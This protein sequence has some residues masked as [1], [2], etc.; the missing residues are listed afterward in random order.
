MTNS[1]SS[2]LA[3]GYA[4]VAHPGPAA[5]CTALTAMA[6][7]S[8]ARQ[9]AGPPVGWRHRLLLATSAMFLAQIST[10][11]LND[12]FDRASDELHQPYKPIPRRDLTAAQALAFSLSTGAGSLLLAARCGRPALKTMAFGLASGWAY[13]AG[14]DRRPESW[15]PFLTG[16]ATVPWL[17]PVAVGVEVPRPWF[18]VA[19]GGALGVGLHLANGGPDIERDRLAGR[20][21]LPVLLG[22]R[23]T[24]LGTHL[25]LTVAAALVV[26]SSPGRGRHLAR[27]GALACLGLLGADRLVAKPGRGPG[28]HPFVLPVLGAGCLAGGWLC[29]AAREGGGPAGALPA[30]T[31]ASGSAP[32]L[33]PG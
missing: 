17:G 5:A 7:W 22:P 1:R 23:R 28:Q 19:I 27:A 3:A 32:G 29:G 10:G 16:I 8:A 13:D 6:G 25:A 12:F 31:V 24:R 33:T 4:A 26:A 11:S 30:A 15:L 2:R 20:R 14:L 21:S 18:T 9:S